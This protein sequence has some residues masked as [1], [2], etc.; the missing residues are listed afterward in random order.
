MR[1]LGQEPQCHLRF[2]LSYHEMDDDQALEDNG[3][4]R[5]AQT[6]GKGAEDLSDTCLAGMGRNQNVLDILGLGC[7]K[8]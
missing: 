3:P 6:I 1:I 7:G 4:C 5:V 2:A 8:L